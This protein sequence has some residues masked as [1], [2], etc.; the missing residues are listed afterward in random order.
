MTDVNETKLPGVGTLHDFQCQSGD[1]I[2]VISHHG[3]RREVVFYDSSDPDRVVESAAM[4]A[5]EA[6]I[7]SDL[8]GGT[9][10][11]EHVDHAGPDIEGLAIDWIPIAATSSFVGRTVGDT[12]L[13]TRTG[14]SIIAIVRGGQPIASPGPDAELQPEDTAVVVGSADGIEAASQLLTS[15]SP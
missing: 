11:T 15:R 5:D 2:G 9:T 13:R 10:V 6:R 1:R 3:D 7:L 12:E 4:T 8:L 14:V